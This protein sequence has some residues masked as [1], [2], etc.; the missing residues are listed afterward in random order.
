M[1]Q[2]L[3]NYAF[4]KKYDNATSLRYSG[5]RVITVES[6]FG[7]TYH[8]SD[9]LSTTS[10]RSE[11]PFLKGFSPFTKKATKCQPDFSIADLVFILCVM[12]AASCRVYSQI[13][14]CSIADISLLWFILS[15]IILCFS[16]SRASR[17]RIVA[18]VDT[19]C[20]EEKVA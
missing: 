11:N 7:I 13:A 1:R 18:V 16:S 9:Y 17:I 15:N 20:H 19:L 12:T 14:Y 2:T 3:W 10:C 6:K 5:P 4:T 8:T